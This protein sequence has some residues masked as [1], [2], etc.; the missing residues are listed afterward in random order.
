MSTW[1][2]KLTNQ[3][4]TLHVYIIGIGGAGMSAIA[5][6]L[7]QMGMRVSGS[8]RQESLK[9]ER[10]REAGAT[11]YP[12]QT[13]DNLT[14]LD[15]DNYPDIVLMSSAI[16]PE[17]PDRQAAEA[18]GLPIVKRD[19]FLPLLLAQ[20]TL[21]AVAGAHGKSTTTSMIVKILHEA[22]IQAGYIIGTELPGYGNAS[23]GQS[24]LFVLEADE[25][26]RMFLGLRPTVAVIT[27]VEWDHV[28][29]YPTADEFAQAFFE[30][31]HLVDPE[32]L[33]VSCADDPG[34]ESLRQQNQRDVPWRTYGVSNAVGL[35]TQPNIGEKFDSRQR[36][37][38]WVHA[39]GLEPQA[40]LGY[41]ASLQWR[42]RRDNEEAMY[43]L[44]L[45]VP[46]LHNVRNALAALCVSRWCG[47]ADTSALQSLKTFQGT[48]RRFE[49]K[50][51][52]CG[53]TVIDDYAHHP[54][55]V[56]VT[57]AAA[58]A[59]YP[60]RRIWAVFQPHTF[61]RTAE[62]RQQMSNC[63][64]HATRVLVTDIYASR[65]QNSGKIHA[66]DLVDASQ[67]PAIDYV[68]SLWAATDQLVAETRAGDVVITLGAG[69]GYRV[70]EMLLE[71]LIERN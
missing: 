15:I 54:T 37:N 17:I 20:R 31:T 2:E 46:G 70:G 25:Y 1:Q 66:R 12:T 60:G 34:A 56:Q 50:G 16:R 62:L 39:F 47:V 33:I 65:E 35:P 42:D 67:H 69:D 48:A 8:D 43:P 9:T 3:D 32:G 27:N 28:D 18:L 14:Q 19:A 4:R 30:F 26:D 10:L 6:V 24:D 22:G 52:V 55:E 21:I 57:L 64:E 40:E 45:H 11:V 41:M 68:S 23:A 49:V 5:T 61:S 63:F 7:L 51:E 13:D 38:S 36:G 53:I 58:Q 44:A 59:R 29:C 71:R